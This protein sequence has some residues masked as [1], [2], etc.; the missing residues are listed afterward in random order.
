MCLGKPALR[1]QL[2]GMVFRQH[3][4]PDRHHVLQ[5]LHCLLDLAVGLVCYGE[6]MLFRQSVA[7]VFWEI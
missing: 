6:R 4:L 1:G 2:R 3:S 7:V 5:Q